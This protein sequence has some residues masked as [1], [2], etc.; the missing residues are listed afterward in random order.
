MPQC[1]IDGMK[2]F[3]IFVV[4]VLFMGWPIQAQTIPPAL[5][6]DYSSAVT[7]P[8]YEGGIALVRNG[9]DADNRL[10]GT[11]LGD[12]FN[13]AGGADRLFGYGG[14]DTYIF[15]AG[16]GADIIF[17]HSVEGNRIKFLS[18]VDPA[19]VRE[20]IVPGYD[21]ELDRLIRYGERDAIR[22]V[23]W[24]RLSQETQA[25]WTVEFA[26]PPPTRSTS[27]DRPHPDTAKMIWIFLK[28]MWL[29][30]LLFLVAIVIS[31]TR[32]S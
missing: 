7:G 27:T 25:A 29:P 31:R 28:G 11:P 19:S 4:V 30:A 13:A 15:E 16:D 3:C 22:I 14:F 12:V 32:R 26:P 20:E 17:D 24:S 23:G 21:G 1:I 2:A 18:S 6:E 8:G 9:N 5:T 10:G